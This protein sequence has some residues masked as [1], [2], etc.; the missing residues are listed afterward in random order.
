MSELYIKPFY[1]I[2]IINFLG[3]FM[4]ELVLLPPPPEPPYI[5]FLLENMSDFLLISIF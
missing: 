5:Y 4:K 2:K 3:D 1:K